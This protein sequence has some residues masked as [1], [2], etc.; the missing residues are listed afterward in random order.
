MIISKD[1]KLVKSISATERVRLWEQFSGVVDQE[2]IKL[3][4]L[5][6][7]H[8]KNPPFRFKL[9][10]K[11]RVCAEIPAMVEYMYKNPPPLL[12][13]LRDVL[14]YEKVYKRTTSADITNEIIGSELENQIG[15]FKRAKQNIESFEKNSMSEIKTEEDNDLEIIEEKTNEIIVKDDD[16]MDV[17]EIKLEEG[18]E[19]DDTQIEATKSKPEQE[20][21]G[22]ENGTMHDA[23]KNDDTLDN[24]KIETKKVERDTQQL[25][26]KT[27]QNTNQSTKRR[28]MTSTTKGFGVECYELLDL[29]MDAFKNTANDKPNDIT[30][31]D[32]IDEEL[33]LLDMAII[34]RLALRQLQQVLHDNPDLVTRLQT[35]RANKEIYNELKMK[36]KEIKLPS[37]L[38]SR[39]DIKKIARQLA[40]SDSSDLSE[41][42]FDENEQKPDIKP[43]TVNNILYTNGLDHIEGDTEKALVIARRLEKPIAMSKI[44]ARAVLT[45]VGDILSGKRFVHL[46]LNND[47]EKKK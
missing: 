15:Y 34:K 42:S 23:V 37:Q 45:P 5:R 33:K 18:A 11:A 21:N 16:P 41:T 12:P 32:R 2:A 40:L 7:V 38:L 36:Q 19:T 10:P 31:N 3:E 35:E 9:K 39:N 29:P 22:K 17:E 25:N 46:E 1:W 26:E 27:E 44:R 30:A 20:M 43:L 47:N 13:S 6:K 24:N 8:A 4:F 14:R 28:R